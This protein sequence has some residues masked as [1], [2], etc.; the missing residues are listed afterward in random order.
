MRKNTNNE[1]YWVTYDKLIKYSNSGLAVLCR[2]DKQDVWFPMSQIKD[3]DLKENKMLLP[4][5]LIEDKEIE[6]YIS[7]D[8]NVVL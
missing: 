3:R 7:E 5:W 6:E 8:D 1:V 2:F 4:L